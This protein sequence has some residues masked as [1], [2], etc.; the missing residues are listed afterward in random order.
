VEVSVLLAGFLLAEGKGEWEE[1]AE[2]AE[3]RE[4]K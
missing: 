4:K 3:R 1:M 2:P